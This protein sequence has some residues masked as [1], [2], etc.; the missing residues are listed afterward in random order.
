MILFPNL[1]KICQVICTV[2][3]SP[4]KKLAAAEHGNSRSS[5]NFYSRS[6]VSSVD[7]RFNVISPSSSFSSSRFLFVLVLAAAHTYSGVGARSGERAIERAALLET[8]FKENIIIIIILD[9]PPAFNDSP[10]SARW[11]K[12]FSPRE[13]ESLEAAPQYKI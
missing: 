1:Y 5:P 2:K 8:A 13:R 9:L 7:F 6:S 4:E 12:I 3:N 11:T 10:L